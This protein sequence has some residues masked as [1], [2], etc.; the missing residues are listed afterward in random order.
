MGTTER[1]SQGHPYLQGQA[2]REASPVQPLTSYWSLPREPGRGCLPGQLLVQ[3]RTELKGAGW[4]IQRGEKKKP[5]SSLCL[6]KASFLPNPEPVSSFQ[7]LVLCWMLLHC[8]D[9]NQ[10]SNLQEG[11]GHL[12]LEQEAM[13]CSR[14]SPG[15]TPAPFPWEVVVVGQ[16]K[17]SQCW[18][19]ACGLSFLPSLD[20][21]GTAPHLV[22]ER[23]I[24]LGVYKTHISSIL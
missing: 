1:G 8:E 4:P 24:V 16:Q 14:S 15:L 17:G 3:G 2:E 23:V 12:V 21:L 9:D 7:C 19:S 5:H 20:C 11:T 13:D 22:W 18:M 10:T 6:F